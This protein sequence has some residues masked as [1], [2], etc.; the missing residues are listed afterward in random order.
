[1]AIKFNPHS[2]NLIVLSVKIR[3]TGE[4]INYLFPLN[5]G[6]LSINQASRVSATFTYGA[7]VFQNLG[8]GL[9]TLS[10]EGHT[11]YKL[12]YGR[13]GLQEG[14][15][16][17]GSAS[18]PD[19]TS[20]A[21]HWLDLY[22]ITQLI[23]GENKYISGITAITNSFTV[24]NIDNIENVQIT[25]PDQGITYD[26]LLQNDS[27][28]R[29]REQPHLYKYKL[30]FIV[31]QESF[32]I[33]LAITFDASQIPDT[34]SLV[35]SCKKLASTVKNLKKSF[36]SWP[37]V[38]AISDAIDDG[39]N[40]ANEIVNV[41][42]FAITQINSTI[43]DLRRLEK[44]TDVINK[45]SANVGLIKNIVQ[46][47]QSFSNINTAFYE[48][49]IALKHLNSQASLLQKSLTGDQQNLAFNINLT[50]LASISTPVTLAANKATVA[51]FQK[52]IRQLNRI[53]FPFPI[54][55]VEEIT[56]DGVTKINVFFK[57]RPSALGISSVKIF[58][59]NDF[60]NENDL[61]ESFGDSKMVL[62][63][64]YNTTGYFYNFII[65]YNYSTFESIVQPKYK[66]IKRIL[67]QKGETLDSIVKKYAS[68]EANASRTYLSEV[69][70]LNNIEYPYIVTSDN[71]NF[72]AYFGSYGYKIF[73]TKGEFTQYIYNIDIGATPGQELPL[74]DSTIALLDDPAV[75]L[76]QQQEV[77][78]Q[79]KTGSKFFVLLFKETYSNRSYAVF[80]ITDTAATKCTLFSPEIKSYVI[81][82]LEKG[83]SYDVDNNSLFE[84]L[85]PYTMTGDLIDYYDQR[86]Y[87]EFIAAPTIPLFHTNIS[88]MYQIYLQNVGS[89]ILPE[90]SDTVL[91][92]DSFFTY[93]E[94]DKTFL[95]GDNENK[96]YVILTNFTAT[97][98]AVISSYV[99][100]AFS[101]YKILADGQEVM[102][103]SLENKFLPFAEAFT[104]EDTYKVD[105]DVR[106]KYLDDIHVSILPR[107]DILKMEYSTITGTF[108]SGQ[109][110]T[111]APSGATGFYVKT[112]TD[113]NRIF[114]YLIIDPLAPVSP[115]L[116]D[117]ITSTT[118][119]CV[120]I[121]A[122]EAGLQ[123]YLDFR[124]ISGL[125]NVKQAIK[126]RL[127]CPQGGLILH[128]NYGLPVL[129]GKKNTLEHLILLRYNLFNQ[130]MSDKRVRST[131]D[132]QIQDAGD[133]INA[134]AS[135]VLVNNDDVLI[136]TTL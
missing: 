72:E 62:S 29:N 68:S 131:N 36:M 132:I 45:V 58:A 1:M 11:G 135:I 2:K 6:S 19:R 124:L 35:A 5:P 22:A 118:G 42:N 53:S 4:T 44:I 34:G 126:D 106:F 20:G 55:R 25:I 115:A 16:M 54:D 46:Q 30:D 38:Q 109:A 66:S 136:K 9:K 8:A 10:I 91:P 51:Q 108:T 104:K 67:I 18:Q 70:Y 15:S 59:V 133:A 43:N 113:T 74:Y 87:F 111:F 21:G 129:L 37:G 101:V 89:F 73:E 63:T 24:D 102:L 92:E 98:S 119:S 52:D 39:I 82:A 93:T 110:I 95:A 117:I 121:G 41:G 94:K 128:R 123:G 77:I 64:N 86:A 65:E 97:G 27:F 100:A 112:D 96:N 23:K 75:F 88:V 127:E 49:Y 32:G 103:P 80:G 33:D 17:P 107:P 125:D 31:V 83:R 71:P 122:Q 28:M 99:I 116:G 85:S 14:K 90:P 114:F 81:C 57:N 134:Q 47:L 120:A 69:A 130:L 56:A 3:T 84:I 50:R 12:A 40:L 13:Y 48:P 7:K 60:G 76:L 61:V 78:D 105:L 26:V 79:L